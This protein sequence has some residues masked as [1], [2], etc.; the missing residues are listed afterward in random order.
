MFHHVMNILGK[1]STTL[2]RSI[3]DSTTN[4][5]GCLQ[6]DS[7]DLTINSS[8][9]SLTISSCDNYNWNGIDYT[10]REHILK[11]TERVRT[12]YF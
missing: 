4:S 10:A 5:F 8:S 3:L 1:Q 2:N 7:L 6:V 11:P 9:N 12:L